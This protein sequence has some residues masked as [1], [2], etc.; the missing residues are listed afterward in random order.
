VLVHKNLFQQKPSQKQA[1]GLIQDVSPEFK[2]QGQKTKSYVRK[3]A[4]EKVNLFNVQ[5]MH[6]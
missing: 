3:K 6:V 4:N 2:P 5:Y 1:G